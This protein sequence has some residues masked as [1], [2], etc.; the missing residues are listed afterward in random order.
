MPPRALTPEQVATLAQAGGL[1]VS[2]DDLPEV[3]VRVNA[4]LDGL[5]PLDALPLA[6][7][8]PIPALP[9][10]DDPG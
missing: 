5:A 9:H 10:P 4:F 3:T 6:T 8:Q 1:R 2:P 7:V